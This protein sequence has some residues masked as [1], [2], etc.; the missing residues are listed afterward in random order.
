M[1]AAN[2]YSD[3]WAAQPVPD[4]RPPIRPGMTQSRKTFSP[5]LNL[6]HG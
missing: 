1:S 3:N 6:E 4:V 5:V 2:N